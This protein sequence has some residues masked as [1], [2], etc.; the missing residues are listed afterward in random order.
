MI[1]VL[2]TKLEIMS[3]VLISSFEAK[4]SSAEKVGSFLL[5]LD[6]GFLEKL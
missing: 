3:M 5:D 2:D 6:L 1:L 4:K